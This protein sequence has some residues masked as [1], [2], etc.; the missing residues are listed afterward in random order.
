MQI[1]LLRAASYFLTYEHYKISCSYDTVNRGDPNE[2]Y[3]VC[4]R[5]GNPF[6]YKVIIIY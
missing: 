2:L 4:Q 3:M 5:G 1:V 6:R